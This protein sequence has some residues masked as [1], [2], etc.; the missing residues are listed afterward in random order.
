MSNFQRVWLVSGIIFG[1]GMGALDAFL[2]DRNLLYI[3]LVGVVSGSVSGFCFGI[4]ARYLS[5]AENASCHALFCIKW[6]NHN[7]LKY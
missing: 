7:H 5:R 2:Y 4:I 1:L 3:L 6:I